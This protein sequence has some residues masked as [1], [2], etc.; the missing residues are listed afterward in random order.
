MEFDDDLEELTLMLKA[1]EEIQESL[2][3][4]CLKLQNV[5]AQARTSTSSLK[6][7]SSPQQFLDGGQPVVKSLESGDVNV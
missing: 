5:E 1:T 7:S 3:P 2:S 4:Y 6:E